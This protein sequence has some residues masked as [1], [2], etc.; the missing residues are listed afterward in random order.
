MSTNPGTPV[1]LLRLFLLY[2]KIGITGF[3]PTLAAETKKRLV[4]GL[5]WISEEEFLNGL[6]LAQLL[7]G[8]T[9][10][11]LSVFIGYRLRGVAGAIVCFIGLLLPPF[12]IM[13]LLSYIYF[14]YGSLPAVGVLFTGMAVVVTG[15]VANAVL[16]IGKSAVTDRKGAIVALGAI[17]VMVY[18]SNIFAL[19][20]LAASAGILL[21]YQPLKR[22][23]SG[24]GEPPTVETTVP[25]RKFLLLAVIL[26]VIAYATSW[27]P[28][29]FQLGWVFFRMGALLFGGGFSMIPFIQQEVVTHYHWLNLDEFMVGL[30]LGQATP[31]PILIT[32]TFVGYKVA[33]IGGAITAT[34]GIFLPSLFLV[35][36]TS[37]IH[38]KIRHNFAVKAAIKGIA[39][40]FA[41]MMVVVVVGLAQYSL[42]DIMSVIVALITF[43]MLR[44]SKLD[45]VWVI[46]AGTVIYWLLST[47]VVGMP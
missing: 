16:E 20:F 32:A 34:L 17:G 29:L 12:G 28:V 4:K 5:H 13:L 41:G 24:G 18:Y 27:Q 39:A 7:P 23:A 31:G 3:G 40:A 42:V 36:A 44:F 30:A 37:E 15:L 19:L 22:V 25:F 43:G 10:V 33:A 6:A 21:Y 1:S 35:M 38:Q 2:L 47:L 45:T 8:A 26:A 11:S 14:T 9:F 46:I